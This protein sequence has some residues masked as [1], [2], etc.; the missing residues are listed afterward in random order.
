MAADL[1][2]MAA[3]ITRA[4]GLS[5]SLNVTEIKEVIALLGIR[6]REMSEQGFLNEALAIRAKAGL[7]S[8]HND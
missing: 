7:G 2:E 5:K 4:E 6:W 1:N 3:E 8:A